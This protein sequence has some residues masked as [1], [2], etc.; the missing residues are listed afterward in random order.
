M[1]GGPMKIS[2]RGIIPRSLSYVFQKIE[3]HEGPEEFSIAISYMEI[4]NNKGY[5]LLYKGRKKVKKLANLPKVRAFWDAKE[6]SMELSNLKQHV[7]RS[8]EQ[9]CQLL[10]HGDSNRVIVETDMNVQSSRSHCIFTIYIEKRVPGEKEATYGKLNLVDLAGS[11]SISKSNAKGKVLKEAKSI[12]IS[13]FYLKQVIEALRLKKKHVPYR[14]SLMTRA[15]HDSLGGNSVTAM[16]ATITPE[17]RHL[18][19]S[20]S[21]CDFAQSVSSIKQTATKNQRMDSKSMIKK[22]KSKIAKLKEKNSYLSAQ[23]DVSHAG[24]PK[25]YPP[26]DDQQRAEIKSQVDAYSYGTIDILNFGANYRA[27]QEAFRQLRKL[28]Q[29]GKEKITSLKEEIT[30]L[31]DAK[32]TEVPYDEKIEQLTK[33]LLQRDF[34]IDTLVDMMSRKR[35]RKGTI[36]TQTNPQDIHGSS[37]NRTIS[38]GLLISYEKKYEKEKPD[39]FVT[40][41]SSVRQQMHD[42]AKKRKEA[43]PKPSRPLLKKIAQ[44]SEEVSERVGAFNL[45]KSRYKENEKIEGD[46]QELKDMYEEAKVV[47][48]QIKVQQQVLVNK[49]QELLKLRAERSVVFETTKDPDVLEQ[50][51]MQQEVREQDLI[52]IIDKEKQQF[53]SMVNTLKDLKKN[54]KHGQMGLS[55]SRDRVQAAFGEWMSSR[56]LN[57]QQPEASPKQATGD[58]EKALNKNKLVLY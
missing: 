12:N 17:A 49:K 34:E 15:L 9:A 18:T 57:E 1:T 32:P 11:E 14:N 7:V 21:T 3:E 40:V 25:K 29:Q 54:I 33:H 58:Y 19:E 22:L 50:L 13:L 10:F 31:R 2:Q 56:N 52:D 27:V 26:L 24:P 51:K 43:A 48:A 55:V 46:K 8:E 47:A 42:E 53:M 16:I 5:D 6:K 20:I 23:D 35:L 28:V 38:N 4:Y 45:F 44:I 37:M 39:S 36:G 41:Q 30:T